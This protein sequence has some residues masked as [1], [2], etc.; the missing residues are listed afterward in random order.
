[1]SF[2]RPQARQ[3]LMRWREAIVG[4]AFDGVGLATV[5]GPTRAHLIFGVLMMSLGS[6]LMYIGIQRARFRTQGGMPPGSEQVDR[7]CMQLH[8][9]RDT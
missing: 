4:I 5:L 7:L 8:A 1:M 6:I 2:I 3:T 9:T